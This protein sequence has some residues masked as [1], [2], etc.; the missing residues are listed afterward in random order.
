MV[1]TGHHGAGLLPNCSTE[2]VPA[3]LLPALRIWISGW[4]RLGHSPGTWCERLPVDS[5]G[6]VNDLPRD[7]QVFL[8]RLW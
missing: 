8:V 4:R 5:L 3:R 7:G 6:A 1:S 2:S